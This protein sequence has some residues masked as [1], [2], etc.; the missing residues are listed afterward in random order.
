MLLEVSHSQVQ[1]HQPLCSLSLRA[2][3]AMLESR[4]AHVHGKLQPKRPEQTA[5]LSGL[6]HASVSSRV[7]SHRVQD[8]HVEHA[9]A[10]PRSCRPHSLAW[11][12][13][14][15]RLGI[16]Q[17]LVLSWLTECRASQSEQCGAQ[18]LLRLALL[19]H[20]HRVTSNER[21]LAAGKHRRHAQSLLGPQR[22]QLARDRTN[23]GGPRLEEHQLLQEEENTKQE[24]E[25]DNQTER[26]TFFDDI[27]FS[28]HICYFCLQ[29]FNK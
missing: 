11:G 28:Y 10:R 19:H 23:S 18:R 2:R 8:E 1:L 21:G 17:D 24:Q 25:R 13:S 4:G 7:Q 9:T 5:R 6:V 12:H 29:K 20:V 27:S 26:L 16:H 3:E 15:T 22:V 14:H